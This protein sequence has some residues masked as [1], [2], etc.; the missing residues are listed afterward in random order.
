MTG[1]NTLTMQNIVLPG[2]Y[3][4]QESGLHYNYFRD[5]DPSTGRYIESDPIGLSGGLNTYVYVYNYPLR[6]IDP[7]G[8]WVLGEPLP[9]W[10]VD[11]SAGLGDALLLDQGHRLRNLLH[12]NGGINE[13]SLD[14]KTGMFVGIVGSL[15]TGEGEARLAVEIAELG[16][17][18][19]KIDHIF[20]AKHRLDPLIA[21][22]GSKEGALKAMHEAAQ[23]LANSNYL[24]GGSVSI[25]VG[26]IPVTLKGAV[27]D[28]VFQISTARLAF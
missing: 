7:Y 17:D 13:C 19:N 28:T 1:Q 6:Y 5:Y 20:Y 27:V 9:Q 11:H 18:L 2:Q 23:D 25:F 8:L 14:Y 10:V 22:Y 4:D 15:L 12:V 21:K 26:E 3:Y 24:T 16:Y